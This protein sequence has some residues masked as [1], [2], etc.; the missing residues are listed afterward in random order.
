MH[1]YIYH[2]SVEIGY[3]NNFKKKFVNRINYIYFKIIK[4]KYLI[5]KNVITTTL[6]LLCLLQLQRTILVFFF[7]CTMKKCTM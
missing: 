3:S 5:S 4:T 1:I 7:N 6:T 2:Y